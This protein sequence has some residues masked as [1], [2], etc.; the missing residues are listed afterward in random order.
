MRKRKKKKKRPPPK[1]FGRPI[2]PWLLLITFARTDAEKCVMPR[3]RNARGK[4][5]ERERMGKPW[6]VAIR[7]P[8]GPE[9]TEEE[10]D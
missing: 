10:E 9:E 3:P 7:S 4:E 6:G 1:T 5:R 2:P 8:L